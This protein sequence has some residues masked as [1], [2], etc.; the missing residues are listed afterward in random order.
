MAI[1]KISTDF[2][3]KNYTDTELSVTAT[4]ITDSMTG[5]AY[6]EKPT[7]TLEEVKAT[8]V[9]YNASLAKAE[10]GSPDDRLVKNSW[11]AKLENNLKDLGLYV[12]LISKGDSLIISSSGFYTNKKPAPVGPLSK[13]ENVSVKMGDN[14]GTVLVNCDTISSATFYEFEYAEIT[15]DGVLNWIHKTS[16]KHKLLIDGLTSGHQYVFRVAGAGS[17]PSRIWS[18]KISTFVI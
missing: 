8:I 18:D 9:S 2:S 4:N 15:A 11:R 1:V 10:K 14:A 16:T 12:Q 3:S 13:P 5:N 6:F 17:D 7:P